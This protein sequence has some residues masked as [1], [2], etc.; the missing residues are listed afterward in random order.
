MFWMLVSRIWSDWRGALHIVGPET[1]VRWHRE[2]FRRHWTRKCRK[3][4]R[5]PIDPKIRVLIRRMCEAKRPLAWT[6]WRNISYA[7]GTENSARSSAD[8]SRLPDY[9]KF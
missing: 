8:K 3:R 2:G 7:I 4:G 9:G 6:T 1:V 5:P